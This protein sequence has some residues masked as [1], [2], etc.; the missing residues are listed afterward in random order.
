[1]DI[2]LLSVSPVPLR[3]LIGLLI[4]LAGILTIFWLFMS[5]NNSKSQKVDT[6]PVNNENN[7]LQDQ[8]DKGEI[9]EEDYRRKL[10]EMDNEPK[11]R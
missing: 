11:S 9:T 8:Y 3:L 1:M 7:K 6:L 10:Q 5:K 2:V 4:L